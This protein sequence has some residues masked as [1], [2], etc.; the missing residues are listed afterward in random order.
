MITVSKNSLAIAS[1]LAISTFAASAATVSTVTI[2]R[3]NA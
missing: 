2:V 1:A 3:D